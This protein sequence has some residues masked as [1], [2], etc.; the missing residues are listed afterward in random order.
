M[1][2]YSSLTVP[3]GPSIMAMSWGRGDKLD[4]GWLKRQAAQLLRDGLAPSAHQG[5]MS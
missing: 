5:I 1:L 2:I 3:S 4:R